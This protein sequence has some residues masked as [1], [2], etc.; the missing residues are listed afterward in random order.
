[1][2]ACHPTPWLPRPATFDAIVLAQNPSSG[3]FSIHWPWLY[4][5]PTPARPLIA[6][7]RGTLAQTAHVQSWDLWQCCRLSRHLGGRCACSPELTHP[8]DM[9]AAPGCQSL[10]AHHQAGTAV[11][12]HGRSSPYVLDKET[13]PT[14]VV[15]CWLLVCP[16]DSSDTQT[17]ARAYACIQISEQCCKAVPCYNPGSL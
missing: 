16:P 3:G 17:S 5:S 7:E 1:M 4:Q 11:H 8:Q 14:V 9:P 6:V 12:S 2:A 15:G 13:S 10:H